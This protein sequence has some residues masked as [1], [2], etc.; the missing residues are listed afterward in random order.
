MALSYFMN[1]Y[2]I[3]SPFEMYLP[4]MYSKSPTDN[5]LSSAICA[6][7]FATLALRHKDPMH[8][9]TAR[10]RYACALTQTNAS[11]ASPKHAVLDT[12]LAA[13]LV[14][15]LFEAISFQGGGKSPDSWT[16]HTLGA[17]Q[18]LRLRGSEQFRSRLAS[19]LFMQTMI[20][21]R[22]SC[23]QR[24][25]AVPQ[26]FVALHIET[27]PFLPVNDPSILIGPIMDRAASIRERMRKCPSIDLIYETLI[28]DKDAIEFIERMGPP[29]RF[30]VRP[31]DDTPTW[32]YLSLAHSYPNYRVAKFWNAI[33]M[34]RLLLNEMTGNWADRLIQERREDVC[35]KSDGQADLPAYRP[36]FVENLRRVCYKNVA[37]LAIDVLASVP[38]FTEDSSLGTKFNLAARTLVWPLIV[39]YKCNLCEPLAKKYAVRYLYEIGQDL[40]IAEAIDAART[41]GEWRVEDW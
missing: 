10:A 30:K 31:E 28:L 39:L 7:A 8:M 5:C 33:R 17:V 12:T 40:N 14:L 25:V 6:A 2:I 18:L 37:K 36:G 27:A 20:N 15:G 38:D 32:A 22:T 13:V 19:Q 9:K 1:A 29:F 24:G 34:I 16:A 26:E 21:I 23:I 3:S 35:S 41:A 11:L 4:T